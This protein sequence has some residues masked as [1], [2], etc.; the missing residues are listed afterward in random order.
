MEGH[1]WQAFAAKCMISAGA[2]SRINTSASAWP[3]GAVPGEVDAETIVSVAIYVLA[4]STTL[5]ILA[6]FT[7]SKVKMTK[8]SHES[9]L[10]NLNYSEQ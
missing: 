10:D 5:W 2:F 4:I 6:L 9:N 3:S 7:F 1:Y 8:A